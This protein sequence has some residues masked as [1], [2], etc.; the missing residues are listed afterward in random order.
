MRFTNLL[1]RSNLTHKESSL[2]HACVPQGSIQLKFALTAPGLVI[3]SLS[4]VTLATPVDSSYGPGSMQVGN[5]RVPVFTGGASDIGTLVLTGCNGS[6]I[7]PSS[8]YLIQYWI[9]D[10]FATMDTV[11]QA[12]LVTTGA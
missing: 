10:K 8:K 6:V 9:R 3:L 2:N 12:A 1:L 11:A 7:Y 5:G 4:N